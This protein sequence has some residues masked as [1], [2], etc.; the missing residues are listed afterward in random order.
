[1]I[2]HVSVDDKL[3][4]TKFSVTFFWLVE[5]KCQLLAQ[6]AAKLKSAKHSKD[7]KLQLLRDIARESSILWNSKA[8]E[9]RL[10]KPPAVQQPPIIVQVIF[11]HVLFFRI[12][13]LSLTIRPLNGKYFNNVMR[14]KLQQLVLSYLVH[15]IPFYFI[16]HTLN[17]ISCLRLISMFLESKLNIP[18]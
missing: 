8:L 10:Y 2:V 14:L 11:L 4:K 17:F 1:M 13:L 9:Q 16:L 5:L 15:F 12:K 7:E 18:L 3:H 6:F